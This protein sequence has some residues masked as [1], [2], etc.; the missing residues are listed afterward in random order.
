MPHFLLSSLKQEV[1]INSIEKFSSY[2]SKTCCLHYEDQLVYAVR[3]II[4]IYSENQSVKLLL[5]LSHIILQYYLSDS[6]VW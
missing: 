4:I 3:D 6:F 2:M 5:F 1:R